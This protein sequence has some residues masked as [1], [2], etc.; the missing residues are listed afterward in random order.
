M[1]DGLRDQDRYLS[2]KQRLQLV[3]DAM[4]PGM[5][6]A[7]DLDG[8]DRLA[9]ALDRVALKGDRIEVKTAHAVAHEAK[10]AATTLHEQVARAEML[11]PEGVEDPE[12]ED[13]AAAQRLSEGKAAEEARAAVV[14]ARQEAET[15]VVK[16]TPPVAKKGRKRGFVFKGDG[17]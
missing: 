13:A 5:A 15:L 10:A 11:N 17:E 6:K 3:V 16:Q 4:H 8:L 14:A 12:V 7:C 2:A 1:E 9:A